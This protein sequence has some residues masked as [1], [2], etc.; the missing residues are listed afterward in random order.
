MKILTPTSTFL[1]TIW[2]MEEQ[3]HGLSLSQENQR[4]LNLTKSMSSISIAHG[5]LEQFPNGL[6]EQC[7]IHIWTTIEFGIIIWLYFRIVS[8]SNR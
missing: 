2:G 1:L 8:L 5:E 7:V 3:S 6:C 4:F